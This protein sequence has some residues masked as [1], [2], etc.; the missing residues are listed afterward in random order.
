[1]YDKSKLAQVT[2]EM[3]RYRLDILVKADAQDEGELTQAQ[4]KRCCTLGE[5][6]NTTEKE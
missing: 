5:M 1:M 4:K 6:T 2:S 3:K